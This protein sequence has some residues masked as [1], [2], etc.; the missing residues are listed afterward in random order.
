L[1]RLLHAFPD[2]TVVV[3]TSLEDDAVA[4]RAVAEGAQDYLLKSQVQ[5]SLLARSIRYAIERQQHAARARALADAR[6]ARILAEAAQR[7]PSLRSFPTD[8]L[9]VLLVEDN[10]A[11]AD[12]V[13][14]ALAQGRTGA[15]LVCAERISEA[16]ELA[17]EGEWDIVLLDLSLPDAQELHGAHRLR[18]AFPELPVIVLTSLD[19]DRVAAG[20]VAEGAQDYLVKGQI[21]PSLLVRSIRYA[22]ERQHYADRARLL[23][24]ERA[25]RI[26]AETVQRRALLLSEISGA[27]FQSVDDEATLGVVARVL[28]RELADWCVI[29]L[30]DGSCAPYL[31]A[32]AHVD[33]AKEAQLRR[34]RERVPGGD[35]P[36]TV[37]A[38]VIRTGRSELHADVPEASLAGWAQDPEQL[39]LLREVGLRSAMIVPVAVRGRIFGAMTLATVGFRRYGPD[40]LA[41]ADE[42][43]RRVATTLDNSRLHREARHALAALRASES[44]FRAV[45][46]QVQDYAIFVLDRDGRVASWS[47][48]ARLLKGWAQEEILGKHLESFFPPEDVALGKPR[49]ELERAA[50]EGHFEEEGRRLRKDGSRFLA[51][52]VITALRDEQGEL[53]GFV[54][55]SRDVTEQRRT[56]QNRDFL[57]QVTH[58]L[59]SALD[60]VAA[61]TRLVQL[62]VP[63]LADLCGADLARG[64]GSVGEFIAT[65]C[66]DSAKE[67]AFAESRRLV[68]VAAGPSSQVIETLRRGEPVFFP[69]VGERELAAIARSPEHLEL[70]RRV[71]PRS[72]MSV[73]LRSRGVAYGA[74]LFLM[75]EPGRRFDRVDLGVA[76]ELARRAELAI[77]NA[78]L[79]AETQRAVR[80]REDVLAVVSH[81]LRS[82]LHA[83]HL[84]ADTAVRALDQGSDPGTLRRSLG[85]I[86]RATRSANALLHDLLDMAS[87]RAGRL[88]I[89]TEQHDA[90]ALV[91]DA[92]QGHE[93]LAREKGISLASRGATTAAVSCDRER[94]QQVFS[95]VIANAVR[96]CGSGDHIAFTVEADERFATFTVADSGPG[97]AE[98]A[99][100][101]VF[102]AYWSSARHRSHGTGLGLF[103]S[104]GIVEAHGGRMWMESRVGDGTKVRFTIPIAGAAT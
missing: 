47:A 26:V 24:E 41:L 39:A 101:L 23:V 40:D 95:N 6:A 61:L 75:T 63:R 77:D 69:D 37:G 3:L 7:T 34:Y 31:T 54:K 11:D 94:I 85:T 98:D 49:A 48:G 5:P 43:A 71:G 66:V 35:V 62:A 44:R 28:V 45:L 60:P 103:I 19:D 14:E 2:L 30:G 38:A 65:A 82:P 13:R 42:I 33:Q 57:A 83:I 8:P 70:I 73:P 68:P 36:G 21:E 76:T 99:L 97:I 56:E 16:L 17:R 58:E 67:Q 78:R 80:V 90:Q 72:F 25:A 4:T 27:L 59:A 55:V 93:A 18:A 50:R 51:H 104:K 84:A 52:V 86:Q 87:I 29:E 79:F 89:R 53:L 88:A 46:D 96:V 92:V 1:E 100:P 81:D 74:A 91:A 32:S 20:A 15:T 10:P 64:D 102:E 22:I 12:L 9:R